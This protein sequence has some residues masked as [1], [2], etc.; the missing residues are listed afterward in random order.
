M[1]YSE[2]S[3]KTFQAWTVSNNLFLNGFKLN[4]LFQ[5]GGQIILYNLIVTVPMCAQE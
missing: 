1:N 2:V 5:K 4:F 3:F